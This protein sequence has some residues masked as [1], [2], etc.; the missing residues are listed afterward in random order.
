MDIKRQQQMVRRF[1]VGKPAMQ[2]VPPDNRIKLINRSQASRLCE[3]NISMISRIAAGQYRP[4]VNTARKLVQYIKITN[5]FTAYTLDDLY[6][7]WDELHEAYKTDA[8][9]KEG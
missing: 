7:D 5:D 4:S 6:R 8:Q 9:N 3:V 2:A 1:Q